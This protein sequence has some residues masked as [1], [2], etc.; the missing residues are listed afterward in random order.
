MKDI[1]LTR[2]F[3]EKVDLINLHDENKVLNFDLATNIDVI[4]IY[5]G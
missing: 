3:L 4:S 2:K 1:C 5:L